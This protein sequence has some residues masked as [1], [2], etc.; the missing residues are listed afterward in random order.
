M[1][2]GVPDLVAAHARVCI[3]AQAMRGPRVPTPRSSTQRSD[4]TVLSCSATNERKLPRPHWPVWP[5]EAFPPLRCRKAAA[6]SSSSSVR[7]APRTPD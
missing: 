4:R 6:Q 3:A 5:G 7:R 1:R 2:Q